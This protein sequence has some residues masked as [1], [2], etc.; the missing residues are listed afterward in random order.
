MPT[1]EVDHAGGRST[2]L[3][4]TEGIAILPGRNGT[5]SRCID[6]E[7]RGLQHAMASSVFGHL[8]SL[9]TFPSVCDAIMAGTSKLVEIVFGC[10]DIPPDPVIQ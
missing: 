2:S 9:P 1:Q 3:A 10:P 6:D 7:T 8:L 4:N 5:S